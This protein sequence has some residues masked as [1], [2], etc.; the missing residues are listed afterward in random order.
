M[1]GIVQVHVLR[2]AAPV[3]KPLFDA[4]K[5]GFDAAIAGELIGALGELDDKAM[6]YILIK[7]LAVVEMKIPEG[8][9]KITNSSDTLSFMY[10]E[11]GEDAY[12]MLAVCARVMGYNFEPLFREAL[13]LLPDGA[14]P[15]FRA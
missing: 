15:G 7:T 11:V 1:S 2:R 14:I 6:E 10:D 8:W 9:A 12:M 13:S 4:I 3:S 5:S